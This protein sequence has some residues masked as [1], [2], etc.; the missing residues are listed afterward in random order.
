MRATRSPCVPSMAWKV[1]FSASSLAMRWSSG[2]LRSR[3]NFS[4]DASSV[5]R[6]GRLPWSRCQKWAA[7]ER[8]ARTTLPLPC[9]ISLP[10]SFASMFET[11]MNLLESVSALGARV[12]KHFWLVLMVRRM[13]S[14]G[15]SR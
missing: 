14:E 1:T 9:T 10:P 15:I 6:S 2:F 11:R 12:T 7:S 5:S 13:I 8:R 4:A 3:A